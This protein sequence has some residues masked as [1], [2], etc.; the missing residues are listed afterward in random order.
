MAL[1]PGTSDGIGLRLC[2]LNKEIYKFRT[3]QRIIFKLLPGEKWLRVMTR[4]A[5]RIICVTEK[6]VGLCLL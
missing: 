1:C 4:K 2:G 6:W 5:V 3:P